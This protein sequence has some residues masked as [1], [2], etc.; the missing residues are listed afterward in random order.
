MI[1]FSGLQPW[2]IPYA[3][4]FY[5]QVAA[6]GFQPRVTSVFRSTRQQAVLYQ[7]YRQG[8]SGGLPA[9]PPGRSL[10][11]R[12]LAFD[13][14]VTPLSAAATVGRYWQSA[15][16]RWFPSDPVHFEVI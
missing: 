13:L 4:F 6:A 14:V 8:L 3:R 11:E 16:G 12:G 15:G 1:S 5:N 10:H 9:A 2:L 7:R